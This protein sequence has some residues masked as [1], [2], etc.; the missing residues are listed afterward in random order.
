MIS[1][2]HLLQWISLLCASYYG[3]RAAMCKQTLV[4]CEVKLKCE[5]GHAGKGNA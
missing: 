3:Q 2:Y 5:L 4:G 1:F